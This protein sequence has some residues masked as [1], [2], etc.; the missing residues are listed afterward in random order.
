[1]VKDHATVPRYADVS[2]EKAAGA[3][4]T[5]KVLADFVARQI[6]HIFNEFP[7]NRPLRILDPAIGDGQLLISL[8]KQIPQGPELRIEIYGFE[9]D[10]NA[11]RAAHSRVTQQFPAVS[12]YLN[13]VDF[14][15]F[16]L[17]NFGANHQ[18]NLLS[19]EI[20][21][22]YDLIIANPPYVRTQIMGSPQAQFISQQF[23]L[24]GRIDLYHAFILAITRVLKSKGVAGIIVSNR[25]LSTRSGASVR[26]A[27]LERCTL[28]HIWDLGD[29]KLFNAAILPAVLLAE[30]RNG[31]QYGQPNFT[32][33]YETSQ[34]P[35]TKPTT[36]ATPVEALSYRGFV[37]V[38][39][40]R[41]FFVQ[42]GKLSTGGKAQ[43]VWRIATR[44]TESWLA[45]VKDHTWKRFGD[46]GKIRVG[47]KT[48]ADKVFI[49]SDWHQMHK[50]EKPELLRPVL[51]HHIAR[52]FKA[53]ESNT[54][55]QILYPHE[56]VQGHTR[57]VDLSQYPNS[58]VYLEN[59]RTILESR[60]YLLKAGRVWYE[61]WVPQVP[62]AWDKIK[63]VFRDIAEEPTFW[64][65]QSGSV[66]NGDCYWMGSNS[67]EQTDILWLAAA[68][69]N[70]S[71]IKRFYDICF[72]N[73]LYARRRRF[74][75]QYVEQF[76]LPAPN[77]DIGQIMIASA[78]EIY[79]SIPSPRT[80]E[81]MME[82]EQMVWKAFGLAIKEEFNGGYFPP[83]V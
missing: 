53:I 65:D 66:V 75:T 73:K 38:E 17:E 58:K 10:Q 77:S 5:P 42:H 15:R 50:E 6:I 72:H 81:I 9:T 7:V 20:S 46:V 83:S 31:H 55:R 27:L 18:G 30:S 19:P 2:E 61:I 22:T 48:C 69:A 16:V 64:I 44:T 4:Y 43:N 49:R 14:L 71:F 70:S 68:V 60:N 11:L 62:S 35:K 57:A 63:L 33:I 54:P 45:T 26:R 59:H 13:R 82:L 36:T 25:F 39:D 23:G 37:E 12:A 67:P 24:S 74:I 80:H 28:R 34:S 56:I 40:G 3:T 51:T 21:E 32:S 47:V 41:Q 8:L 1:M 29:S 79:T 52:R 78:K 76:P